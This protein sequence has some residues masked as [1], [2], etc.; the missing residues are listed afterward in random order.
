MPT[1]P[2]LLAHTVRA[3]SRTSLAC[4]LLHSS[5]GLGVGRPCHPPA[6]PTP[7]GLTTTRGPFSQTVTFPGCDGRGRSPQDCS[8]CS[9]HTIY[10]AAHVALLD[11]PAVPAADTLPRPRHDAPLL[12]SPPPHSLHLILILVYYARHKAGE[13]CKVHTSTLNRGGAAWAAWWRSRISWA[14]RP[15]ILS[16]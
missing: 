7:P 9:A 1:R 4:G 3:P 15:S 6:A 14:P 13:G 12:L 5:G 11:A 16:L 10:R 2:H 8:P